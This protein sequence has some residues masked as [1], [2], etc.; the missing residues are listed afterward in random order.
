MGGSS[1]GSWQGFHFF[2]FTTHI[3]LYIEKGFNSYLVAGILRTCCSPWLC[4]SAEWLCWK[5]DYPHDRK[6][7]EPNTSRPSCCYC[8]TIVN[9]CRVNRSVRGLFGGGAELGTL[10]V[11]LVF[12]TYFFGNWIRFVAERSAF[13]WFNWIKTTSFIREAFLGVSFWRCNVH[14]TFCSKA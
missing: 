7:P 9:M 8:K 13:I 11:V 14:P 10:P 3:F 12:G 1:P 4:L 5:D 2:H 6:L